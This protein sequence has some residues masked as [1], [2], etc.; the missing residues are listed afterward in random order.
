MYTLRFDG[1]F[2]SIP[3]QDDQSGQAGFMCYGWIITR[4]EAV[5]AQGHGVFTRGVD[6]SSNVAEYIALIEGMDALLDLGVEDDTVRILGDAKSV[7]DQMRG[8]AGVNSDSVWPLYL[9]ARGLARSFLRLK[10]VWMPRKHN[11]A[12]DNLTRRAMKQVRHDEK[13]YQAAV[14][15]LHTSSGKPRRSTKLT[16]VF[17]LRIYQPAQKGGIIDGKYTPLPA[18]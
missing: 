2:R 16:P 6:A 7:I 5:V 9:R 1:L 17:D 14:K 12:A 3:P 8:L 11:K 18:M 10:W 13:V 15:S 4:G